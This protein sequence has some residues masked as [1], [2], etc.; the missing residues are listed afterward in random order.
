MADHDGNSE[1]S[2]LTRR[3]ALG[4]AATLGGAIAWAVPFVQTVDIRAA[5]AFAGSPEP[6]AHIQGGNGAV[7]NPQVVGGGGASQL[8]ILELKAGRRLRRSGHDYVRICFLVSGAAVQAKIVKGDRFSTATARSFVCTGPVSF[9]RCVVRSLVARDLLASGRV[10]TRWN[11]KNA[12]GKRVAA[13]RYSIL[14]SATDT[15][16]QQRGGQASSQGRV[17]TR[18]SRVQALL[19]GLGHGRAAEGGSGASALPLVPGSLRRATRPRTRH[20]VGLK[21]VGTPW[22]RQT[23]LSAEKETAPISR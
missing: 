20:C 11:G 9:R 22:Q 2:H 16:R 18:P 15:S 19:R 8:H 13:G 14:V 3:E 7:T 1:G 5:A 6:D 10:Q 21:D 12:Q 17:L 23:S 4:R